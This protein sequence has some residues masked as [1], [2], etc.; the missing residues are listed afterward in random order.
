MILKLKKQI[1]KMQKDMNDLF[2]KTQAELDK[3]TETS[4]HAVQA[5][6]KQLMQI[7]KE[8]GSMPALPAQ[9][10]AQPEAEKESGSDE[11]P[12]KIEY[13]DY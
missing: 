10:R 2:A 1:S 11:E 7:K 13:D 3:E 4:K 9:K 6:M 5:S 12:W 8:S